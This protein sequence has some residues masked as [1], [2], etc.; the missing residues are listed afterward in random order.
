MDVEIRGMIWVMI[1]I[2]GNIIIGVV[3][4]GSGVG[5]RVGGGVV[6]V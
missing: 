4:G 6:L 5:V 1:D 2:M 3:D